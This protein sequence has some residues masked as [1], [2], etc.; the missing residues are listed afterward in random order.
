MPVIRRAAPADALALAELA[1]RT[2]TDTFGAHTADDDLALF[3]R[4]AYGPQQQGEEIADPAVDVFVADEDGTMAGFAQVRAGAA[5]DCVTDDAPIELWRFYVDRPWHGR[6]VAHALMDA[7][8]QAAR[9][10]GATS[11]WLSVW[12][13]NGRAQGYYA[14]AGFRQAGTKDFIVGTDIQTDWVMVRSLQSPPVP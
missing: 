2:Y 3:L 5:P 9:S 10:R 1:V 7:V 12:E 14:K 13:H 6:G 8:E 4:T 11:L